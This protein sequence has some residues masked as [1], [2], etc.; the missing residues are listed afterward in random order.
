[1]A[2]N[3][4]G[5]FIN[6]LMEGKNF[7]GEELKEG[8]DIT[9]YLYTDRKCYYITKVY[10]QKR[11]AVKQ[12]YVCGDHSKPGGMGHQNW[13]YF[14]TSK[15]EVDYLSQVHPEYKWTTNGDPEP[16]IWVYRY[17]KWQRE[18]PYTLEDWNKVLEIAK[19]DVLDPNNTEQ[20]IGLAKYYAG[21]SDSDLK[22]L[23]E[24]KTLYKYSNLSGKISFGTRDYYRDWEF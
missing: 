1:M 11:I 24:G 10:N 13:L 3:L 14:K 8:V 18:E 22:K 2:R 15:E 17:G 6:R 5:S 21:L 12:Y 7:T 4:K 9:M 19:K 20:V 23:Q 16:D